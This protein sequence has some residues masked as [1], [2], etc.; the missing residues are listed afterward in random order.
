MKHA[1]QRIAHFIFWPVF[2]IAHLL[3]FS[4]L[5]WH[6]L[7]QIDFA[8]PLGY[9]LLDLQ[10]HIQENAPENRFKQKFEYTT[11]QEHWDLFSQITYAIQH[12]GNGLAEISYTLPNGS[13]TPLMHQ[14]EII[15]LQDVANLID[16]I[17]Q[18]GI[19]SAILWLALLIMAYRKKIGFP[20]IKKILTGFVVSVVST[21][22]VIIS[23]GAKDIF[24]WLH[25]KIF[26]DNHQWFFF[27]EESLMTTLM[28]APHIFAFITLLLIGLLMILWI[29]SVWGINRVL[30]NRQGTGK[31]PIEQQGVQKP[32]TE[33]QN[34]EKRSTNKNNIAKNRT[35]R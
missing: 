21:S 32:V 13:S 34:S 35:K 17:Y 25:T 8:Y 11:P 29:G 10:K 14:A 24:Y 2:F 27:Y 4:I 26:P 7:A 15:H 28:K 30:T 18:I 6:L 33:K 22:I 3:T 1:M 19:I 31:H 23:L 9:K 5:S 16:V 20:A 12:H